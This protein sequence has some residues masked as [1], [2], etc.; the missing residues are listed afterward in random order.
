MGRLAINLNEQQQEAVNHRDGPALIVAGAG[1]GKTSVIVERILK[2]IENGVDKS[3]IL[4]LTFTEKAAGEMQERVTEKMRNSYG[5]DMNIYTF[6]A[7]GATILEEFGLE[8][9][10]NTSSKLL[11]D[12]AKLVVLR[13]HIDEL[14]L[15]YF[16]PVSNPAGQLGALAD[17]FSK[18]K[19]QLVEIFTDLQRVERYPKQIYK[20]LSLI[21]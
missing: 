12:Q 3:T 13:E 11:G 5:L 7:F 8:I 6:N 17:Y 1:T 16:A 14:D 20:F 18:L 2:L 15:D 21:T 9:G 19:Q 10:L 4:A